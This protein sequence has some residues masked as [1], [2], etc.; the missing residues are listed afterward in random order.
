LIKVFVTQGVT[1]VL[2]MR[3][4]E[5][6]ALVAELRTQARQMRVRGGGG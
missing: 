5:D 6:A 3:P 1:A 4:G 2:E